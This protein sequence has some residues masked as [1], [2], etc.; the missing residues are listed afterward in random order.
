MLL[1]AQHDCVMN[2]CAVTGFIVKELYLHAKIRIA[3]T[4]I[5]YCTISKV[6]Q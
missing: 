6:V 3:L 1:V 4:V 5:G 2:D